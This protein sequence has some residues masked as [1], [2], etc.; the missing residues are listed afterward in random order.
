MK[1]YSETTGQGPDLVLLHGWGAHSGVWA[2]LRDRL[3]KNFRVT[4]IDLPGHGNSPYQAKTMDSLPA[5]AEAVLAI[6][7]L[8]ASWLGWS[9]GGLVAQQAAVLEPGRIEKL[10]LLASTPSF[11]VRA[12]WSNAVEMTVFEGFYQDLLRDAQATLLRFIALQTRG[13]RQAA[14][15]ARM[16]KCVLLEVLPDSNA[17]QAG[18]NLLRQADMREKAALI[19]APTL[20]VAGARD[21]LLPK[22]ALTEMLGLFPNAKLEVIDKA[23]HAPFLSHPD[24]TLNA[25]N[26]FMMGAH[27]TGQQ[28]V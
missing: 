7:P 1:L 23:G 11:V 22:H 26:T 2:G 14:E 5:V 21:T 18:L 17:L 15:D 8:N 19:C 24:E 27:T 9:L 28:H 6:A 12:G 13:S 20:L 10:I 4:S 16:L 25:I 3:A